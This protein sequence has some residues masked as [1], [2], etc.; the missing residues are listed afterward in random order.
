MRVEKSALEYGEELE[1]ITKCRG[2]SETDQNGLDQSIA[3][4]SEMDLSGARWTQNQG[5]SR[6][7]AEDRSRAARQSRDR[8]KQEDVFE[9]RI[10]FFPR[11]NGSAIR[12]FRISSYRSL[13]FL[14]LIINTHCPRT[15]MLKLLFTK[16][17]Q[18]LR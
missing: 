7:E 1:G 9:M 14:R 2:Q 13:H 18:W 6:M 16:K 12:T 15:F 3:E 17:M 5:W 10:G 4:Q 8:Q 11:I